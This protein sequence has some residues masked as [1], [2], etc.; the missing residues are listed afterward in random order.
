MDPYS[1]EGELINIHNHFHQGQYQEVVDFDT[2]S[3]SPENSL[4]ARVLQ[5]RARIALGQA[6]DVVA[7]VQG[8]DEPELAAVGALAELS[9]GKTDSAVR[10]VEKLAASSADNAVVQAVGGAVLQAAGKSEEAL[11]LL[12]Q[13]QGNLEAVALIAQIHLQ[14]N[15][16][17]LALKEVASARRWAQDSLLVNLAEAWLGLRLGGEK[18]QQA[19]YV[20]EELAQAPSTS[21]VRSLV[22]QAVAEVH[23]GRTE[24]AQA[25]LDQAIK[26]EPEFAEAIANL[27]VLTVITGKDPTELASSLAK[28][29]S[30]HPL[31]VDLAE[32][33][34][35]FDKAASK[36]KAKVAA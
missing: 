18:Y 9:L 5:L 7:D 35:L 25:A 2:S 33:S 12:S 23:L 22:S 11:A 16:N 14:Q 31:L 1:A 21:S 26:K 10:T 17:D 19:F 13:H 28:V 34:D 15:R 29:D 30:Q 4:P 6:E 32:K 20:F 3:L 8:E 24:E 36:Y 27:L